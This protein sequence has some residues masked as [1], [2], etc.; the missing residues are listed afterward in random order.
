MLTVSRRMAAGAACA[1]AFLCS[2]GGCES[3]R[4]EYHRVPAFYHQVS[5]TEL[6]DR[7]SRPDGTVMVF[8]TNDPRRGQSRAGGDGTRMKIREEA[9][10]GTIQFRAAIPEHVIANL[11]ACLVNEEYELVY[12]GLLSDLT[13]RAWEDEGSDIDDFIDHFE[14]HRTEMLR[15]LN[16]MHHGLSG[17]D[18]VLERVTDDIIEC[19]LR[20]SVARGYRFT[21]LRVIHEG[22]SLKLLNIW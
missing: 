13:R 16:R 19:R 1:S 11:M 22:N 21:R 10:D 9:E 12:T 3:Y 8:E 6:P 20:P 14:E 18:T 7:T 4:V 2:L 5:M 15:T 17:F